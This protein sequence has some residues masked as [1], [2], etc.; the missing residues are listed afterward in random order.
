MPKRHTFRTENELF[1]AD[2][3]EPLKQAVVNQ[4]LKLEAL[5]RGSYPGERLPN[6]DLKELCMAGYWNAT[7]PQDWGLD[8]HRNEG[9]EIGY[10]NAGKLPFSVGE[11]SM[12]VQPGYLTI[13]RPWLKHRVG[14]PHVPASHYSWII[15]DVGVRRPNQT[16]RWPKWMLSPKTELD[17]LTSMLRQNEEPVWHGNRRIA[18]CFSR[19]DSTV[20]AGNGSS[21]LALLKIVIN[22]LIVLLTEVLQEH[23]PRLDAS[24]HG[25]E[26]T[27]KLF[28]ESLEDRL[29]EPW[30]LESMAS[31]CG[32]GRTQFANL[33]RKSVNLSPVEY[34]IHLRMR[35]AA[36]L[37]RRQPQI[38]VTETAF[39][40]G[41]QSSQYFASTFRQFH[42]QSPS[43]F[44]K[45]GK[46]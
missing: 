12:T 4:R 45:S 5:G 42:G 43:E 2:T 34:L 39:R 36:T 3:C 46:S 22:E 1:H 11:K 14:N 21:N 35:H 8:W 15:L 41:F 16:W 13:T 6:N 29:D 33:C 40:C 23:N 37:L 31:E 28:L 24:L 19:L 18:E 32:L 10:V 38:G 17:R 30:T 27:V 20:A 25:S 44:R 7:A 9:I 26:R